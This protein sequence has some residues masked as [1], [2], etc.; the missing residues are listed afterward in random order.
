MQAEQDDLAHE[1]G[2]LSWAEIEQSPHAVVGYV[3][4]LADARALIEGLENQDIPSHAIGLVDA[5]TKHP[6]ERTESDIAES[7][8]F[9]SLAKSVIAGGAYGALIGVILGAGL[10]FFVADLAWYWGGLMGGIFGSAVGGAAGGMS[11]AKY[12]SPAWDETHQVR[13]D[14]PVKVAVHH[15]RPEVVDQAE[16]IMG[17]Y[18][19]RPVER[20]DRSS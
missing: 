10:S 4:N 3:P 6:G 1:S 2:R 7:R 5:E 20:L 14:S 12:S 11:V 8:A 16:Q 17:S 13:D 15:A 9:A 18:V 19:H